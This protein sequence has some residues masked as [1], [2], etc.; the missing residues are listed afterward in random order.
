MAI[1]IGIFP[2]Q[3]GSSPE[4]SPLRQRIV[5][6]TS[7]PSQKRIR[8]KGSFVRQPDSSEDYPS[9]HDSI[10]EAL[11]LSA[12]NS[13]ESSHKIELVDILHIPA[14]R[15]NDENHRESSASNPNPESNSQFKYGRGTVLD[16]ITE[17]RSFATIR[18]GRTKSADN[19]PNVSR[20]GHCDSFVFAKGPRRKLSFSVDDVEVI[21]R[22]YHEACALIERETKPTLFVPEIYAKPRTPLHG[23][24]DRP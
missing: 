14:G 22:N 19:S 1:T 15:G 7:T 5:T 4:R 16:T 12:T 13:E 23:P 10:F 21:K 11:C 24:P 3:F 9:P 20:L 6:P 18:T 2:E 17:Q 8:R